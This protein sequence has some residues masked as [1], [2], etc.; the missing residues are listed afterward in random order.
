M[1]SSFPSHP[2]SISRQW[3][4]SM[5]PSKRELLSNDYVDPVVEKHMTLPTRVSLIPKIESLNPHGLSVMNC[6]DEDDD[7]DDDEGDFGDFNDDSSHASDLLSLKRRTTMAS[8]NSMTG[9]NT[10]YGLPGP[11]EAKE[12]ESFDGYQ[13]EFIVSQQREIYHHRRDASSRYLNCTSNSCDVTSLKASDSI[14]EQQLAILRQIQEEN[15]PAPTSFVTSRHGSGSFKRQRTIEYPATLNESSQLSASG[16]TAST[17]PNLRG[18]PY[19]FS[20]EALVLPK[21]QL[22]STANLAMF[23]Q[24]QQVQ[25]ISKARVEEAS[26]KG[27]AIKVGCVGCGAEL[28][29]AKDMTMVYCPMCSTL[30]PLELAV[31]A[32]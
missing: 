12:T 16:Q 17:N 20:D 29:A 1:M 31:I 23:L 9:M 14:V 27:L 8:R 22:G 28:L 6:L 3:Q 7:E 32:A 25:V 15:G 18:T 13:D 30:A 26:K 4:Q 24:G 11:E 21:L 10:R 2:V 5:R 19:S